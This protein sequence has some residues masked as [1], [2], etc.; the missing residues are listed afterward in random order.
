M[1]AR[2]PIRMIPAGTIARPVNVG[3]TMR[4]RAETPAAA[5]PVTVSAS[6][7]GISKSV[8]PAAPIVGSNA[9]FTITVSNTS[10]AT[11]K[12]VQVNEQLSDGYLFVS[13]NPSVGTYDDAAGV[14][15]V[16]DLLDGAS[17]TLEIVATVLPTGDH[18]NTATATYRIVGDDAASEPDAE[19]TPLLPAGSDV[20]YDSPTAAVIP[21]AAYSNAVSEVTDA[22]EFGADDDSA[23]ESDLAS[24]IVTPLASAWWQLTVP[25]GVSDVLLTVDTWLTT[26]GRLN[27]AGD[28]PADYPGDTNLHVYTT[29]EAPP[30]GPLPTGSTDF[31]T[32]TLVDSNDDSPDPSDP[33]RQYTSKLTNVSLA[34]GAVYWI[35]VDTWGSPTMYADGIFYRL[36][37]SLT[38]DPA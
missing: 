19:P 35:R 24:I 20:W 27:S 38:Y 10:G 3:M 21:F 17:E 32:L 9:T 34:A 11:A 29:A 30:L 7:V 31:D 14:W 15:T 23:S 13:S 26:G 5:A 12:D 25:A 6:A 2:Y 16:G 28:G 33:N 36:R 37:V 4:R 8:S 1:G 22:T 18:D